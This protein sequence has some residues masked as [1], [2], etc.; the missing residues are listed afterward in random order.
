M[1]FLEQEEI[2]KMTKHDFYMAALTAEVQRSWVSN[3]DREKVKNSNFLIKPKSNNGLTIKK[4]TRK[5]EEER[6]K[7]LKA[8]KGHW[9][10]IAGLNK[11]AGEKDG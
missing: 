8:S 3:E 7:N 10:G 11:N 6:E 5:K 9:F 2:E 1:I 4:E